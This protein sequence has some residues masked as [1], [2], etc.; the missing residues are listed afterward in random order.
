MLA[1][2]QRHGLAPLVGSSP[3]V[4]AVGYTLGGGLGWL[5]RRHGPACDAVRSFEVVTPDGELVRACPS[6]H[7]ELFR[8]LRGGGGCGGVV[9]DMEIELFPV[10]DVYAGN[11]YYPAAAA[12]DVVERWSAWVADVPDELTSAVVLMNVP[13]APDIPEAVRGRSWTILRGC[14]SGRLDE[15]RALLDEWRAMMPPE[16]DAWTEMPFSEVAHI[17]MD[18]VDPVPAVATG[19]W[20]ATV[21]ANVGAT[22]AAGTFAGS[23]ATPMLCSEIRH[24]GGAVATADRARSTMGNRDG[25][26]LLHMVGIPSDATGGAEVA[27][28]QRSIKAALGDHLS[29]RSYINFL[30]GDER[31]RCARTAIDA[32]DLAAIR[33]LRDELDPNDVL[34]FGIDHDA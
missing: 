33:R 8:A 5:A 1:A 22:L 25:E 14:W 32:A 34:R 18:P 12:A 11:L 17:S 3:T 21:D 23:A 20:L 29:G 31:R 2:A 10:R 30:D 13:P 6:E 26:F 4:G 28:H 24:V 27:A 7:P 15:G 16:V 19:G 9:T